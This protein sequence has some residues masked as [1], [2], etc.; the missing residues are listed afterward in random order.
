[1]GLISRVSSR[2]YRFLE[3][4]RVR[5]IMAATQ[6]Q[7]AAAKGALDQAGLAAEHVDSVVVGNVIQSDPA[8]PYVARHTALHLGCR[9]EIPALTVNRL[10]GSGFQSVIDIANEIDLGVS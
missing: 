1:M 9:Q 5:K 7:V 3:K 10:C 8:C 6:M 4:G 2:T